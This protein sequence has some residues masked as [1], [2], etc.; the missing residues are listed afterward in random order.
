MTRSLLNLVLQDYFLPSTA[1]VLA[2]PTQPMPK[3]EPPPS[4]YIEGTN[5]RTFQ[6]F[7]F[8]GMLCI[9]CLLTTRP[10]EILLLNTLAPHS[11]LFVLMY[12]T[13]PRDARQKGL[14]CE[15]VAFRTLPVVDAA[16]LISVACAGMNGG[17]YGG[18]S[19]AQ[20][21]HSTTAVHEPPTIP[22]PQQPQP[23]PAQPPISLVRT[24]TSSPLG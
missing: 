1:P 13:R 14:W 10:S 2:P 17:Y 18:G 5:N 23:P 24:N 9:W 21:A 7:T 16:S 4:P 15:D 20:A 11:D 12:K 8:F 6:L 3:L 19:G 22:P